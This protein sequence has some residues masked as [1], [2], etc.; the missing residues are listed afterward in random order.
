MRSEKSNPLVNRGTCY[1]RDLKPSNVLVTLHDDKAVVKVID[2][3]I[4]KATAG[5]DALPATT[6]ASS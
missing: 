1:H 5:A 4:A 3:G 2:F 6:C